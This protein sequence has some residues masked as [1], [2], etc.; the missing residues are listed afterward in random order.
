MKKHPKFMIAKNP[1][2][3]PD[4]VYILHTQKPRFLAKAD[5]NVIEIIDDIDD[6]IASFGGDVN[7]VEGLLKR[8]MEWYK[9]YKIFNHGRIYGKN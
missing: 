1:M 8:A 5:K 9:S 2:A 4:G 3:D 6:I 7:K